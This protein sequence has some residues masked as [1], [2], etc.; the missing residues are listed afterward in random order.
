MGRFD[1]VAVWGRLWLGRHATDLV[2]IE[3]GIYMGDLGL[4]Q[5]RDGH[6]CLFLLGNCTM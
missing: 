4:L 2:C 5:Y 1:Y 6:T 3:G